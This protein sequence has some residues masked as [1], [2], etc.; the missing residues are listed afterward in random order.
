MKI[1]NHQAFKCLK[2]QQF[3]FI[4][5]SFLLLNTSLCHS[6]IIS[7]LLITEIMANPDAVNDSKG[8]WFEVFNSGSDIFDFNGIT[9]SD[10]GSNKH[11]INQFDP[12]LIQ[13]GEYFIFGRN[14][15]KLENGGY[16]ADYVYSNFILGNLDDEIILTDTLGNMLTLEYNNGFI[17]AGHSMELISP[18]MLLTNYTE[19]TAFIYGDGDYGTPGSQGSYQFTTTTVPEPSS[20]LLFITGIIMLGLLQKKPTSQK[21]IHPRIVGGWPKTLFI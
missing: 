5:F 19:T 9:L 20:P 8:E 6:T 18:N 7:D 15:N 16:T 12:L 11:L 4:L 14:G 13:P 2:N 17:P 3:S 1:F 21:P 10:N